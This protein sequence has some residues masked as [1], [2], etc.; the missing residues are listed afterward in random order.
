MLLDMY[1]LLLHYF[2]LLL[3]E[4]L[5]LHV[6]GNLVFAITLNKIINNLVRLI[7]IIIQVIANNSLFVH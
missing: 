6:K 7:V 1:I 4:H 3:L 5:L 2:I